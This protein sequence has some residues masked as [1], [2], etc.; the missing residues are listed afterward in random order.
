MAM[1]AACASHSGRGA[2]FAV[3]SVTVLRVALCLRRVSTRHNAR[4]ERLGEEPK[5]TNADEALGSTC[6]KNPRKKLLEVAAASPL[7][8]LCAEGHEPCGTD[9]P[10]L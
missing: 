8:F 3:E 2:S 6:S 9:F 1:C 10:I 4:G 7:L 5:V